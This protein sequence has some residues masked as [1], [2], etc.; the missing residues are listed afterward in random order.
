MFR[1][2]RAFLLRV[3]SRESYKHH[4]QDQELKCAG[5]CAPRSTSKPI[6]PSVGH[7]QQMPGEALSL[8]AGI[9]LREDDHVGVVRHGVKADRKPEC[10]GTS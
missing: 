1:Q 3:E 5:F 8:V 4:G 10:A 9:R 6:R 2:E 7:I